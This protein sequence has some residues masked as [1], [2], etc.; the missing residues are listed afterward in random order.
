MSNLLNA[1]INLHPSKK[2]IN[3]FS[4]LYFISGACIVYAELLFPIKILLLLGICADAI[5]VFASSILLTSTNSIINISRNLS[6]WYLERK[7]GTVEEIIL[8]QLISFRKMI[9]L[10]IK[11]RDSGLLTLFLFEDNT[12]QANFHYLL[13]QSRLFKDTYET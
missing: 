9:I 5:R 8:K 11:I 10:R 2:A 7:N 6:S 1:S 4:L 3:L 12:T 13:V